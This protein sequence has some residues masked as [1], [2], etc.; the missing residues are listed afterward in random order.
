MA[1]GAVSINSQ[2]LE[3]E[4]N[5]LCPD[6]GIKDLEVPLVGIP[7]ALLPNLLE[8]LGKNLCIPCSPSRLF[9][10]DIGGMEALIS[11]C[12]NENATA[13][14]DVR[15]SNKEEEVVYFD[16]NLSYEIEV[17]VETEPERSISNDPQL[18]LVSRYKHNKSY[19]CCF[20]S[21]FMVT[22]FYHLLQIENL[23]ISTRNIALQFWIGII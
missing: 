16:E 18:Q 14:E 7:E 6:I 9:T 22:V 2:Q 11:S 8:D 4:R 5:L 21:S 1:S 13:F 17:E 20:Y 15:S 19:L 12:N 3:R 10:S 23:R